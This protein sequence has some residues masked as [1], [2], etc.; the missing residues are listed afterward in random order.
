M[1]KSETD[2]YENNSNIFHSVLKWFQ[3]NGADDSGDWHSGNNTS[4]S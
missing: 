3:A 1:D 4:N 2:S